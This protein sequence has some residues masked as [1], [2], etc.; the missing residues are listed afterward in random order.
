[1]LFL[2]HFTIADILIIAS[3]LL[4]SVTVHEF[5][6]NYIGYLMGDPTPRD[7]GKL[8]LNPMK[9]IYWPGWLMW[10]LI[11]FGPLGFAPINER[12]MRD[13]RWGYLAAVA[14]GPISNLLMA[15]LAAIPFWLGLDPSEPGPKAIIP[16]GAQFLTGMVQWNVL[17]FLFNLIP[18]YGFDGW[19]I[20]RK[21]LPPEVEYS[22]I[23]YGQTTQIIF[24][25]AFM[26]SF[27][28]QGQLNIIG[29]IINPPYLFLLRLLFR[30]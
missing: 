27:I 12:R 26:L 8:T 11:G 17:L 9:H 21:L 4:I 1:V 19:Q 2:N 6:H 3:V 5:A 7:L 10:V 24:F 22:W 25:G 20:V 30:I 13:P 14:A 18:V 16:T 23:K 28:T 29:W 15:I